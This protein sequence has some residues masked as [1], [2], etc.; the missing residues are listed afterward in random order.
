MIKH[1]YLFQ[2][3]LAEDSAGIAQIFVAGRRMDRSKWLLGRCTRCGVHITNETR[4]CA[5]CLGTAYC[6]CHDCMQ[7]ASLHRMLQHDLY[8]ADS[9]FDDDQV[10]KSELSQKIKRMWTLPSCEEVAA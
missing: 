6:G 2:C 5:E 7:I 9:D 4:F 1:L 8:W 10:Y 3:E